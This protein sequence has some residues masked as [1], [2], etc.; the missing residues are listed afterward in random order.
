MS[1][2]VPYVSQD[3]PKDPPVTTF[4]WQVS[5]NPTRVRATGECPACRCVT[6]RVWE[7]YQHVPKGPAAD[8]WKEFA[9]GKPRYARCRCTT[10]H[11][12]RPADADD[13]CGASFY[14]ALPPQGLSL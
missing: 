3:L 8:G 11:T 2:A 13:G 9:T 1:S 12:G 4:L 10:W 14:V 5:S 6:T 7:E